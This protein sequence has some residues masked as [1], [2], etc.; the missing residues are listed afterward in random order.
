MCVPWQTHRKTL[1][2]LIERTA[3]RNRHG[4]ARQVDEALCRETAFLFISLDGFVV[5]AP[6]EKH[7]ALWVNVLFTLAW[8]EKAIARYQGDIERLTRQIGGRGI[9]C[10]TAVKALAAHLAQAG[11]RKTSGAR[12]IQQWEKRL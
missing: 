11:Y 5:L 12:R 10:Q 3:T 7:G 1:L 9:A 4:F 8:G 2:P 6:V